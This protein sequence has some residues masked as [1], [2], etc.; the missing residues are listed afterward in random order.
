[1][2]HSREIIGVHYPSDS[3]SARIFARQFVNKLFQ[4]EAFLKD[5]QK[6]KEEW[7]LKAKEDFKGK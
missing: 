5:F 3:E 4:N 7:A 6:V 2:A 1:M